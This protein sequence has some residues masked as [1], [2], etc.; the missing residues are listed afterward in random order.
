MKIFLIIVSVAITTLHSCSKAGLLKEGNVEISLN[1]CSSGR[2]SGDNLILCFEDLIS[3]SRCPA[4][5]MCIWQGAAVAKFSVTK[6]KETQSF[7]LSTID[8]PDGTYK[9]EI[10]LIGYKIEFVNLSP[11]AG[12]VQTPVPT[13]QIKAEI[14]ITRL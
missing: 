10:N 3:D 8:I 1:K 12:T 7:V 2:L 13:D 4:N 9:K 11:Y 6:N 14:K 5:A